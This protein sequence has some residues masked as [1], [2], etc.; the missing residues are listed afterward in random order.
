MNVPEWA[1]IEQL[2]VFG[3]RAEGYHYSEIRQQAKEWGIHICNDESVQC[4]LRK[5]ALG[6]SWSPG[7]SGGAEPYLCYDDE[8][9]LCQ[10]IAFGADSLASCPT[11]FVVNF[12]HQLKIDRTIRA[13][14]LLSNL[15]CQ[16]LT[17][18]LEMNPV[19]PSR[20]WLT[21]FCSRHNLRIRACE[22]L[23]SIRRKCCDRKRIESWFQRN[24][25]ILASYEP[26]LILNMDET[27]ISTN[28]KFNVVV[29]EGMFP[30]VPEDR[31]EIHLTGIVTFSAR[32]KLFKPGVILPSLK[33]LPPELGSVA[34]ELEIYSSKTGWMTKSI[35]DIFCVN[36]AHQIDIWRLELRQELRSKRILLI[37]DGH[38]SRK[39]HRGILY[40]QQHQIDVLILPGHST[41][42]L[43]PFDVCIASPL[44]ACL[45]KQ[46]QARNHDLI[47]H[48][49]PAGTA[50]GAR[51]WILVHSFMESIRKSVTFATSSTAFS[52]CGLAP[53]NPARPLSSHLILPDAADQHE[54]DW[55]NGAYFAN[56]NCYIIHLLRTEGVPVPPIPVISP[57]EILTCRSGSLLTSPMPL[58]ISVVYIQV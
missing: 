56:A 17:Q 23:E 22:K 41:H 54:S 46:I 42:I 9:T 1:T 19:P 14:I 45:L 29:P 6:L 34:G 50:V 8:E 44:K 28:R 57:G 55:L 31:K 39:S 33:L 10:E 38:G 11:D 5:C 3:L 35:F 20:G 48:R 58:M 12:A 32:G 7:H 51:R 13:F 49:V 37:M 25:Q 36:L 2:T 27:G 47:N 18:R 24:S 15:G 21:D 4:C 40:L 30:V 53:V 16:R 26:E 52:V 43:Q